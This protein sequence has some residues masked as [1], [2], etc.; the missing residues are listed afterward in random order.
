[1]KNHNIYCSEYSQNS[2]HTLFSLMILYQNSKYIRKMNSHTIT[3]K[4]KKL[5]ATSIFDE[6]NYSPRWNTVDYW[7]Y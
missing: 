3:R 5:T 6:I 1:M 7:E 4:L 2:K